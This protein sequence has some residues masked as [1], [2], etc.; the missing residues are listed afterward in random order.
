[1]STIELRIE[2]MSCG[3]CVAAVKKA[4]ASVDGLT[5]NS[6][7]IGKAMA[8]AEDPVAVTPAMLDAL[9]DAG[10]PADVVTR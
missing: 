8:S 6:V 5:V 1:M 3:H 9:D 2:G 10:Y 7:E 4:L